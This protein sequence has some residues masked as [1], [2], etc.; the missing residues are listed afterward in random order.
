MVDRR[1]IGPVGHLAPVALAAPVPGP[2]G[3]STPDSLSPCSVSGPDSAGLSVT[4]LS[5]AEFPDAPRSV[6]STTDDRRQHRYRHHPA[7][8]AKPRWC[9]CSSD[10]RSA[11]PFAEAGRVPPV[12]VASATDGSAVAA[13]GTVAERPLQPP[14]DYCSPTDAYSA[15]AS[16]TLGLRTMILQSMSDSFRRAGAGA[17]STSDCADAETAGRP[18]TADS[19]DG[20][21]DG[22]EGADGA[23]SPLAL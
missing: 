13:D 23:A 22:D 10:C 19:D 6:D 9:C 5:A 16:L 8:N 20:G 2:A 14:Q 15:S 21:D 7:W 18:A 4:F 12:A 17:D 1:P 11:S 3:V